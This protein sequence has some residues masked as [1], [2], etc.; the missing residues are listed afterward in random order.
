MNFIGGRSLRQPKNNCPPM[1]KQVFAEIIRKMGEEIREKRRT[2]LRQNL[3]EEEVIRQS[4]MP[5][6]VAASGVVVDSNPNPYLAQ[7]SLDIYGEDIGIISSRFQAVKFLHIDEFV[8][9]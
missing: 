7:D 3:S 9:K 8:Y 2:L 6:T 1:V 4:E 5:R